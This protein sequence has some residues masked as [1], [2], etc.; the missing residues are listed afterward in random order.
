AGSETHELPTGQRG[1]FAG[2]MGLL[3]ERAS[4]DREKRPLAINFVSPR[5]AR[6]PVNPNYRLIRTGLVA[7]V[8]LLVGSIALGRMALANEEARKE[9]VV[10]AAASVDSQLKRTSANAKRLKEVDSWDTPV[11]LDEVYDLARRIRDVNKLRV[12]QFN[13]EPLAQTAR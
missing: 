3:V 5:Q 10:G 12:T 7:G 2:A 13:A 1:A 8:V 11:W 4:A 9:S 6:P